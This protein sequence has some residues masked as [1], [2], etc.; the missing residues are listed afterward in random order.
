MKGC[1]GAG[2]DDVPAALTFCE[3]TSVSLG[4]EGRR[5]AVRTIKSQEQCLPDGGHGVGNAQ[6]LFV[7]C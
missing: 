5:S 4:D 1:C 2:G 7:G 3:R 6:G